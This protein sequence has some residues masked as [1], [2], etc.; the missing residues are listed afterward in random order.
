MQRPIIYVSLVAI[1]LSF[2]GCGTK[3]SLYL[4]QK[5]T[6]TQAKHP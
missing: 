3:G 1:L 5:S 6:Q 4:P 2:G